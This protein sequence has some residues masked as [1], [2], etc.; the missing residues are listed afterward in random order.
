MTRR[1]KQE[2]LAEEQE[3][4]LEYLK[5]APRRKIVEAGRVRAT[6]LL[7]MSQDAESSPKAAW[8][9]RNNVLRRNMINLQSLPGPGQE[10]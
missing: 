5:S 7:T 3:R 4:A 1:L 2:L 8:T 10:E 9:F 6:P